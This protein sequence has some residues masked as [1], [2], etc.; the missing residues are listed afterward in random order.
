MEEEC[1]LVNDDDINIGAASKKVCHRWDN[2]Q[3]GMLHRAFSVFLF[4]TKGELLIQQRALSKI[5]YPG[6]WTNTCCSHPL[7]FETELDEKDAGGVLRA[8]QRKLKHELG[9]EPHEVPLASM[10]YL[11]RIHYK[12]QNV[13]FDGV[14]GEHEID[15]IIFVQRDVT[16]QLNSNEVKDVRYVNRNALLSFVDESKKGT[17][18]ITP[19]FQLIFV[20][21]LTTWWN[22]LEDLR[23]CQDHGMIHRMTGT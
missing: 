21:F 23:P 14:W 1:I 11:T 20:H 16:L 4:N 3:K 17:V 13:P 12:S 2:I 7:N 8:A 10:R 18:L 6:H 9:I 19:W 5:T 15:Y 22:S